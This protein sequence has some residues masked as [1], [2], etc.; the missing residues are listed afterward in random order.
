M[1]QVF[2]DW[3]FVNGPKKGTICNKRVKIDERT[4]CF[5]HCKECYEWNKEYKKNH[6]E[7]ISIKNKKYKCKKWDSRLVSNCKKIDKIYNNY[8]N[9]D[10]EW[11]N[12]ILNHQ[13][14][15]CYHCSNF[16]LL[17]NGYRHPDQVSIDRINNSLGHIKGN[18][19]LACWDCNNRRHTIDIKN[20][21]P[22]PKYTILKDN[23]HSE[24][25]SEETDVNTSQTNN[26]NCNQM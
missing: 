7:E 15:K 25:S 22:N 10:I 1:T 16:L 18:V 12:K 8:F 2:C 26:Q 24:E 19:V 4:K 23:E 9:L 21:T 5:K 11:I 14:W 3:K 20:F 17:E 6:K 13:E